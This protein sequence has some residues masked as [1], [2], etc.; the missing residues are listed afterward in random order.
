MK[1]SDKFVLCLLDFEDDSRHVL[2]WAV[3][4]ALDHNA[5]LMIVY[6]YRLKAIKPADQ[7]QLLKKQLEAEAYRKF[8]ELK[9]DIGGLDD[10][11]YT[12]SPEVGFDADRAEAHLLEQPI[13]VLV[14]SKAKMMLPEWET[15]WREF[16]NRIAI[17]VVW[18]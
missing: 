8:D 10:I 15:E 3:Q 16:I 7:K 6:P 17:P 13:S 14:V 2:Q 9:A 18:V 12:F 11:R 1:D 4:D 5:A